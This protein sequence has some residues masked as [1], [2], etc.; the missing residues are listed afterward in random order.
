MSKVPT[1]KNLF[2]HIKSLL[3]MISKEIE[4]YCKYPKTSS[5]L[6]KQLLINFTTNPIIKSLLN[7]SESQKGNTLQL[8]H[9]TE[10]AHIK[11]IL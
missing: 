8:D 10:L 11:T 3:N 6:I 7:A 9:T 2:K 5:E 1:P 4:A